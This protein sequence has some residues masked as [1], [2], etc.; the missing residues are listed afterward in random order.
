MK[1]IL[2]CTDNPLY[3]FYIPIVALAWR[4]L[5]VT[6][7][8]FIIPE[9]RSKAMQY[10]IDSAGSINW[11][12]TKFKKDREITYFQV[13]RL[14][15]NGASGGYNDYVITSDID[16]I[17]FRPLIDAIERQLTLQNFVIVGADLT[18]ESQYPMC[19]AAAYERTW[20][21]VFNPDRLSFEE[22]LE[23][24]AGH[25]EGD[26][27]RGNFWCL[28]QEI[29]KNTVDNSGVDVAK[30]DR[31]ISDSQRTARNRADRDGWNFDNKGLWDSHLKRPGYENDN[32]KTIIDLLKAQ[33]PKENFDWISEYRNL[34]VTLL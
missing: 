14:L 25:V 5:G 11:I 31:R 7:P 13:A 3:S 22:L 27:I 10:A 15:H 17:A 23:K 8:C 19:Y 20:D 21:K 28:D 2:S 12:E 6:Y 1:V 16:M 24:N 29:L 32:V 30:I 4:M 26:N 33:H 18:P 34:F 9:K